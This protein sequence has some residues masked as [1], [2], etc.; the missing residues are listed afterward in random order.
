VGGPRD[1]KM[2]SQLVSLCAFLCLSALPAAAQLQT[3]QISGANLPKG[4]LVLTFDDG[5]DEF[6]F[7]G[8]NQ[9]LQIAA[10]LAE[11][12]APLAPIVGTFFLNACHFIGAPPPS[13]LSANCHTNH[14]NIP[15]SLIGQLRA[16]GHTVANHGEDHVPGDYL[17]DAGLIY[18]ITNP[19]T[20]LAGPEQPH[21]LFRPAGFEWDQRIASAAQRNRLARTE[22]GPFF[23]DFIGS[24]Y[25]GANWI[26]GDW[27]CFRQGYGYQACGDLY[28]EE[29]QQSDHGGIILI[30]DR[31]PYRL[32]GQQTFL[33]LQYMLGQLGSE[34]FAPLESLL[35]V[36]KAVGLS[37][38][39]SEF[40]TT[41][42]FGDIVFGR[43]AG[44]FAAT[45]CKS[46]ADG[47]WC[48][49]YSGNEFRPARRW[50]EFS[51]QFG[52]APGQ[53][54]WLADL[55][56]TGKAGLAWEQS[57][58]I[59]F[60]PSTYDAS[61]GGQFHAPRM[62]LPYSDAYGWRQ[63]TGYEI[64]FGRFDR[65][66]RESLLV[67]DKTGMRVFLSSGAGLA[68]AFASGQ[69][70]DAEGWG[71]AANPLRVGD[72][73]G[74]GI[75]DICARGPNGVSCATVTAAG[76]G[77]VSL[78]TVPNGPFSDA[79]GWAAGPAASSSFALADIF[80]QGRKVP[81]GRIGA[82]VVFAASANQSFAGE[83]Q[84]LDTL[85]TD[86]TGQAF[87]ADATQ[88]QTAPVYFA[89]I[90]G[91]GQDEA[92][93]MLPGGLWFGLTQIVLAPQPD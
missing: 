23:A 83:Q 30:H 56:G 69:F 85:P 68:L 91:D 82:E 47:I 84:L 2:D 64:R 44:G 5:P 63:S 17:Q 9:T 11:P 70:A 32:A 62:V 43:I 78:Y 28:L 37:R 49:E 35:G 52:L 34:S 87:P 59:M 89:D 58:G 67:R 16:L 18:E 51:S 50:F 65:S 86:P 93:W 42:G 27:D 6:Q 31:S 46:R 33:M 73:D 7:E 24:G 1:N 80:G 41:D 15:T 19:L 79:E 38:Q 60:A 8:G 48:M 12:P 66:G 92:V 90:D 45:P 40:G 77:Q 39:S 21:M 22:T 3:A 36:R 55:D 81:A 10:L 4:T 53:T 61:S 20:L 76:I 74:D 88:W 54:F 75:D 26:Q 13:G 57:D 25:I 72:I 29:I 71:G 14:G